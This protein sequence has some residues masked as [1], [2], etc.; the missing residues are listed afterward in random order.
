M[1]E[2]LITLILIEMIIVLGLWIIG[3]IATFLF[4]DEPEIEPVVYSAELSEKDAE[5]IK[6]IF[7]DRKDD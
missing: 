6:Q 5:L 2:N 1:I 3:W 4:A 7:E